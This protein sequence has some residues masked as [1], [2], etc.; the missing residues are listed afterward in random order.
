MVTAV[1][2][3]ARRSKISSFRVL[4]V[5]EDPAEVPAELVITVETTVETGCG[6]CGVWALSKRRMPVQVRD[7]ACF[8]RPA[9]LVRVKCRWRCRE[10]LCGAKISTGSIRD[11]R[12]G[13]I[14][15]ACQ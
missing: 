7:L 1:Q 6:S 14:D 12:P 3:P 10:S 5:V 4:E 2:L 15:R 8:G 13:G 11:Q 9:R